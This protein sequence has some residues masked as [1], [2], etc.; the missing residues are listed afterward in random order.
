M[1]AEEQGRLTRG[2]KNTV[3]RPSASWTGRG[4]YCGQKGHGGRGTL[5]KAAQE[6]AS[7]A[8]PEGS[9]PLG[10]ACGACF[11]WATNDSTS[12]RGI[13]STVHCIENS[14]EATCKA[15]DGGL[16]RERR[17]IWHLEFLGDT[18]VGHYSA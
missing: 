4:G 6:R 5:H 18:S 7:G 9:W 1:T 2:H 11:V 14:R 12:N 3:H 17:K 16:P 13:E 8:V 15:G 10:Y